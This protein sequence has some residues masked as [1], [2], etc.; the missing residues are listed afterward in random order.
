MIKKVEFLDSFLGCL[1]M[2]WSSCGEAEKLRVWSWTQGFS[3]L[4]SVLS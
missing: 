3:N 2:K 1:E 4:N